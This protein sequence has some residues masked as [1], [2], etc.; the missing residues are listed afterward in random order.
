MDCKKWFLEEK[1]ETDLG[2]VTIGQLVKNAGKKKLWSDRTAEVVDTVV[3]HY[4]SAFTIRP[5]DP[6]NS[7]TIINIFCD[8]GVSSHFF[9][10]RTGQCH[11]LV[12]EEKKAWHSGGSIMPE[13]DNRKN[14]N[15][16]SVGI[17]LLATETSGFTSQQY[18]TLIQLCRKI[19]R[20]FGK[21]MIYVGHEQ[22]A[23]QRAVKLGLRRDG[24][25]DPGPLFD[26]KYFRRQLHE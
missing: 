17:E 22:I 16:F 15:D 18:D 2:A 11:Q 1:N 25:I 20:H 3:I 21:E 26:W 9:I 23:G 13:P 10:D 4:M 14:V 24:K 8:Y 6:Y 7:K 19:E 12:P 5:D